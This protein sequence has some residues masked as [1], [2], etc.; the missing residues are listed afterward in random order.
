MEQLKIFENEEFGQ[1]RT[2]NIDGEPWFVGKDVA[3]ILGYKDTS[4]AMRR[5]VDDEDN[6]ARLIAETYII[7]GNKHT[8]ERES[9]YFHL[10]GG[11]EAEKKNGVP[12]WNVREAYSKYPNSE[13]EL[14]EFLKSLQKGK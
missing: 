5:H 9:C 8:P 2:I 10:V 14:A 12:K 13:T 3:K 4:D 1:V 7:P 11:P 6:G